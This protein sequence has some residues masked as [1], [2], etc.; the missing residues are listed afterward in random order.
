MIPAGAIVNVFCYDGFKNVGSAELTCNSY[1][2]IDG[3][4]ACSEEGLLSAGFIVLL[5]SIEIG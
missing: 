2:E 4:P 3:S 1:G 5:L